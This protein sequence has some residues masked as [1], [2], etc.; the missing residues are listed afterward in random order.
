VNNIC[1]LDSEIISAKKLILE[2]EEGDL[3]SGNILIIDASGLKGGLRKMR[4]GHVF[5]GHHPSYVT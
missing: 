1:I 4:D 3:L 5:F 2:D